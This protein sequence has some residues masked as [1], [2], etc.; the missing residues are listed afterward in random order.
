MIEM[1]ITEYTRTQ[2][3][4]ERE[5]KAKIN[6]RRELM[7]KYLEINPAAEHICNKCG[8]YFSENLTCPIILHDNIGCEIGN[9]LINTDYSVSKRTMKNL[10][11][12]L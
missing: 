9:I 10:E 6:Q 5:T 8:G 7:K 12:G 1:E 2:E 11:T 3:D 4:V